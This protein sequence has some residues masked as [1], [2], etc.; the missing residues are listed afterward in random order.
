MGKEKEKE[1][2]RCLI[3]IIYAPIGSE[4]KVELLRVLR[5]TQAY[6]TEMQKLSKK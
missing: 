2:K 3:K 5:D 1:T 6:C 4:E